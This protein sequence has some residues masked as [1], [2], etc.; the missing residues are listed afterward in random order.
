MLARDYSATDL[1]TSKE[2][3][4]L[5]A[6][7]GITDSTIARGARVDRTNG[8]SNIDVVIAAPGLKD[9]MRYSVNVICRTDIGGA[10]AA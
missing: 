6:V 1:M 5:V 4:C 3:D 10:S 8:T 7:A 9:L 2:F